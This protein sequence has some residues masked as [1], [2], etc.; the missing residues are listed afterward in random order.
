MDNVNNDGGYA[1]VA[2]GDIWEIFGPFSQ[3]W[4]KPET[5][6]KIVKPIIFFLTRVLIWLHKPPL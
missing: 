1:S 4:C 5:T 2:T 3:F 6:L